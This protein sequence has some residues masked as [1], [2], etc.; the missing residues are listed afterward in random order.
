M[1]TI[2]HATT[3]HPRGDTRIRVKE[4]RSLAEELNANVSLFV[5]DGLMD[6]EQDG[7]TVHSVGP[8]LRRQRERLRLGVWRMYRALCNAKPDVVHFH[9]PELIPIGMLLKLRGIQVIYDVHE[10]VPRQVINRHGAGPVFKAIIPRVAGVLESVGARY[11]D[12]ICAATP[13][14]MK[15]FPKEK[16]FLL[17][18]FPILE[19]FSGSAI[20]D[21]QSRPPHFTYVGGLVGVRGTL[22]MIEAMM[23]VQTP[24]ARLQL[25][26][27]FAPESHS[28]ECEALTGWSKVDFHGW[29]DRVKI[30][31]M[32]A[33]ARAGLVVLQ[34]TKNYPDALPVKLFEYMA[35][36]LPVISSDFPL[37]R[38][39]VESSGCGL[40]V[41]PESPTAIAEAMDWIL[42]HPEKAEA[43]GQRGKRAAEKLYNWAVEK[44]ML[45]TFYN[46]RLDVPL[47]KKYQKE[48]S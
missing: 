27:N 4:V 8:K 40:L 42:E 44:E 26:G 22:Q 38:E 21:Y 1:K 10:D 23:H 30:S 11:F 29:A 39:I 35:S 2:I 32:L 15:K 41:D 48:M 24:Q 37:W 20:E 5:M 46:E 17:R 7:Y 13:T 9:D 45:V 36:G 19:E 3:V 18:N 33:S 14:I 28:I 12:G 16:T 25:A 47:K 31:R 6:E 43:M 34:P